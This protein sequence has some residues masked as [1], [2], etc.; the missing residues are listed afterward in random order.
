MTP[1]HEH[2]VDRRHR[3]LPA[4][5]RPDPAAGDAGLSRLP[6]RRG[7]LGGDPDACASAAR[8]PSA[9]RRRRASSSACRTAARRLGREVGRLPA[10]QPADGGEPVLGAGPHGAA[11][12]RPAGADGRVRL[13]D[14]ALAIEEE[15]GACAGPSAAAGAAL[16]GD[17]HGVLTHCNTGGLATGGIRHGPGGAV[18]RRRAGQ[19]LPRLRRRDPAAA[20]RRPADGVGTAAGRH[21]RD[22]DLRQHGGPG[23]EGR[24]RATRHRRRR[25]HR[26]QR[27]HGQQDRHLRRRR[28]G[29]GARHSVLRR[30]AVEHVRPEPAERRRHSRSSSATRAR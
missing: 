6:H 7:R 22:A 1:S 18:H 27:R 12:A 24:P 17:G 25:P 19:A 3:R 9:S 2:R 14:E 4:P 10:H 28:A 13:L 23:D 5:A 26:R 29:Q 20:A 21:R 16:I 15:D 30:G 11:S 8:R